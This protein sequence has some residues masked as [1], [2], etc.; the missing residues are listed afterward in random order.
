[1]GY[2]GIADVTLRFMIMLLK[3]WIGSFLA[4]ACA[5]SIL[6]SPSSRA[7][8]QTIEFSKTVEKEGIRYAACIGCT[9]WIYLR[10]GEWYAIDRY[11][12][13]N[14]VITGFTP[15]RLSPTVVVL[16][17]IYY[18]R[19]K[20]LTATTRKLGISSKVRVSGSCTAK[21]WTGIKKM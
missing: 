4:A 13:P 3:K 6:H 20:D 21:G 15:K 19:L 8:A 12:S 18:C 17:G 14:E 10:K 2:S 9:D 5:L 11:Q 7:G 1:M 16:D